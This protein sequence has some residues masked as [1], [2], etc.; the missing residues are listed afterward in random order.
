MTRID[1]IRAINHIVR[2]VAA[3]VGFA[4]VALVPE[5]ADCGFA[6]IL[7]VVALSLSERSYL[8]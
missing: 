2:A 4:T 3:C 7:L 1:V 5:A 6:L 8:G